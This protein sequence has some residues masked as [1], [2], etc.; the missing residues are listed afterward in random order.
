M[1]NKPLTVLLLGALL[2]MTA[3]SI[4]N[5]TKQSKLH[6]TLL[7]NVAEGLGLAEATAN[8]Q[9]ELSTLPHPFERPTTYIFGLGWLLVAYGMS[10][11]GNNLLYGFNRKG[12]FAL[13]GALMVMGG[14]L[15][16]HVAEHEEGVTLEQLPDDD[17]R[18]YLVPVL[19]VGGWLL[20]AWLS[21]LRSHSRIGYKQLGKFRGKLG[22]SMLGV[23]LVLG[24]MMGVLP[25]ER[26]ANV[27]DS[28]GSYMF[29]LGWV[30]VSTA[31]SMVA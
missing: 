29:A 20:V 24:S 27:T 1:K 30:A 13:I 7:E 4:E 17:Y 8:A 26:E 19:F 15:T 31:N 9:A 18:K 22:M 16:K 6:E 28:F 3:V 25:V 14:V 12:L 21:S 23:A 2:I 5:G 11:R 10:I